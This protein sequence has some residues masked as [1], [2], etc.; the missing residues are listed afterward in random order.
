[1][2]KTF[3]E[4]FE[5]INAAENDIL[6]LVDFHEFAELLITKNYDYLYSRNYELEPYLNKRND[7]ERKDI[8][9]E[10]EKINDY[11]KKNLSKYKT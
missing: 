7:R 5:L 8:L 1:M 3:K 4:I 9:D 11:I 10:V 2:Q 6:G